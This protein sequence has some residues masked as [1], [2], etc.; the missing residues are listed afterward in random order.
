MIHII[1][2]V[3]SRRSHNKVGIYILIMQALPSKVTLLFLT[4]RLLESPISSTGTML[5]TIK[6]WLGIFQ[7]GNKQILTEFLLA[8]SECSGGLW[9]NRQ[10][11]ALS[12]YQTNTI[13]NTESRSRS[14]WWGWWY[15]EEQVLYLC[16][17]KIFIFL[18]LVS[19][20]MT[21]FV[22]YLVLFNIKY[23]KA[24]WYLPN[25]LRQ[26]LKYAIGVCSW[27]FSVFHLFKKNISHR[28]IFAPESCPH[29]F[30]FRQI[31]S[32]S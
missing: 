1:T 23:S 3:H 13:P 21:A 12:C 2:A 25:S 24:C 9:K 22:Y 11:H 16:Q 17:Q 19:Q 20:L 31:F 8:R 10:C 28:L 6:R 14:Q 5:V 32:K 29:L 7:L 26:H 18:R 15:P 30:N 27:R 4:L